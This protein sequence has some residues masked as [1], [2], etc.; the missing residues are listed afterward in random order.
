[1]ADDASPIELAAWNNLLGPR[2]GELQTFLNEP[3]A[4][5]RREHIRD[6]YHFLHARQLIQITEEIKEIR[7]ILQQ[8]QPSGFF[9]FGIFL[10]GAI[11]A[12]VGLILFGRRE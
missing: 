12:T 5:L 11:T 7:C 2:V 4:V 9:L 10:S 3:D 6:I 8:K 1:M